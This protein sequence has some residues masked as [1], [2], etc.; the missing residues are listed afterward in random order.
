MRKKIKKILILTF[1]I[2]FILF[3]LIGLLIPFLQGI[4]FLLIGIALLSFYF[5]QTT[6]ILKRYLHKHPHLVAKIE[7]TEKKVRKFIEEI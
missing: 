2:G 4:I 6:T 7:K 5:P 1:G 3:G